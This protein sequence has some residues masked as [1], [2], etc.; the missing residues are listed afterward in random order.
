MNQQKRKERLEID[1]HECQLSKLFGIAH[2]SGKPCSEDLEVHH[3]TYERSGHEEMG[4]LIVV[5]TRCH[6]ILTDAIRR[7]RYST[8]RPP[9]RCDGDFGL[10]APPPKTEEK[11]EE[12]TVQDYGRCSVVDAQRETRRQCGR[13]CN[14]NEG[15]QLK[16]QKDYSGLRK[17]GSVG[18]LRGPIPGRE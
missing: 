8:R 12:V 2:L 7:E 9:N 4:D 16:S 6:D 15:D 14:G 1:N 17:A 13:I 10:K 3:I 11:S 18:V 5:C